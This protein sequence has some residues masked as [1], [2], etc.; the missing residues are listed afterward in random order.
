MPGFY[1]VLTSRYQSQSIIQ[2]VSAQSARNESARNESARDESARNESGRDEA[3]PAHPVS[4]AV[5]G[6]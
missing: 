1:V 3:V 4:E 5:A 2:V 6:A